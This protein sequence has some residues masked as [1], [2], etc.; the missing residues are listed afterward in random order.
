MTHERETMM[1]NLFKKRRKQS[2]LA[3][4][5]LLSVLLGAQIAA[6]AGV[7]IGSDPTL[8][9]SFNFGFNSA[10]TAYSLFPSD[11]RSQEMFI[12]GACSSHYS[13]HSDYNECIYGAEQA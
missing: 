3:A 11:A 7:N 2:P 4:V 13:K 6:F 8:P 5:A 12:V 10:V 1:T 9:P